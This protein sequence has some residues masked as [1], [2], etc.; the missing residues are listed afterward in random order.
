MWAIVEPLLNGED[1]MTVSTT[2]AAG[3]TARASGNHDPAE[4]QVLL[5]SRVSDGSVTW[6]MGAA[7]P[8]GL[9]GE[10]LLPC[11]FVFIAT[12]A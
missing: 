4:L 5:I 10:G 11:A 7:N 12:V 1:N 2:V 3:A 9:Y 6:V 8:N